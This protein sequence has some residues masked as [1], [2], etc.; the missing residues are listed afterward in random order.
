M[1]A[2]PWQS[3]SRPVGPRRP[4]R[5]QRA[6]SAPATSVVL[7]A[8]CVPVRA[9]H[10]SIAATLTACADS[11]NTMRKLCC[12]RCETSAVPSLRRPR[13]RAWHADC[14]SVLMIGRGSRA[15]KFPSGIG[16]GLTRPSRAAPAWVS[17][18][19]PRAFTTLPAASPRTARHPRCAGSLTRPLPTL[20]RR[21]RLRDL[22]G[23]G[24]ARRHGAPLRS[25]HLRV[26]SRAVMLGLQ[27]RARTFFSLD[28]VARP[29]YSDW[30]WRASPGRDDG[31]GNP[32]HRVRDSGE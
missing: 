27:D 13:H 14:G 17:T 12:G 2:P 25:R 8:R 5:P 19:S 10:L 26:G 3:D 1:P 23:A 6:R 18:A 22:C 31:S 11:G 15:S 21:F 16:G 28:P 4:E 20:L 30:H 24:A 9:F 32:P 7:I 29:A